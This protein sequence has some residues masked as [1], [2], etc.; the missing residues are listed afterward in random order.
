MVVEFGRGGA[1]RLRFSLEFSASSSRRKP[2]LLE[3]RPIP[4]LVAEACLQV[5][6]GKLVNGLGPSLAKIRF[7]AGHSDQAHFTRAFAKGVVT[8]PRRY[9]EEFASASSLRS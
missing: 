3:R 8:S 1:K 7:L 4:R 2:R 6:A 9:R 5:A